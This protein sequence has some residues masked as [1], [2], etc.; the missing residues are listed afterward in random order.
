MPYES[1]TAKA[2]KCTPHS[3]LN[4]NACASWISVEYA[5]SVYYSRGP[6]AATREH[7]KRCSALS[8]AELATGGYH[9]HWLFGEESCSRVPHP[10]CRSPF[11]TT[12]TSAIAAA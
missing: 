5:G 9:D 7:Q 12:A 10:T 2:P 11:L 4:S 8:S 6:R 3:L 1:I